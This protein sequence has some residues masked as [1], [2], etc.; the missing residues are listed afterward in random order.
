MPG[1]ARYQEIAWYI[2]NGHPFLLMSDPV[3]STGFQQ[4]QVI[5]WYGK[6]WPDI[7]GTD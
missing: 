2:P 6:V 5:S 1:Y 3:S 4:V 7:P